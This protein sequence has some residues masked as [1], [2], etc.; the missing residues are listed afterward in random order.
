MA[1]TNYVATATPSAGGEQVT[2]FVV[3][4]GTD[5]YIVPQEGT[6]F[7]LD[8]G[9]LT[10][11]QANAVQVDPATV[12]LKSLNLETRVINDLTAT[13]GPITPGVGYD[14]IGSITIN[15]VRLETPEAFT[16]EQAASAG[17]STIQKQEADAWGLGI[18]TVNKVLV[19]EKTAV[20]SEAEAPVTP[21]SG[22]LLSKVT[23]PG[24]PVD[25]EFSKT[26]NPSTV[27]QKLTIT[28]GKYI[29]GTLTVNPVILQD[30]GVVNPTTTQQDARDVVPLTGGA[31]GY[32]NFKVGAVQ[33][34]TLTVKST[35]SQETKNPTSGKFFSQVTVQPISLQTKTVDNLSTQTGAI[36]ADAG[37]DGLG[38]VTV[39]SVLLDTPATFT[40]EELVEGAGGGETSA[41]VGQAVV[42]KARVGSE[43]SEDP[44]YS[45]IG[46]T[47]EGAW[48]VTEV[49]VNKIP[50]TDITVKS[51]AEDQ[52]VTDPS[53]RYI[54][55]V[56]VEKLNIQ[57]NKTVSAADNTPTPVTPDE[58]Y[59][60]LAKVT[61]SGIPIVSGNS[62][63]PSL[64]GDT[65]VAEN[66]YWKN[67][68]VAPVPLQDAGTIPPG[69]VPTPAPALTG[70]NI[71]YS[72]FTV[73]AIPLYTPNAVDPSTKLQTIGQ[74]GQYMKTV[75][76][77]AIQVEEKSETP[78]LEAK[79]VV[80]TPGKYLTKV[81]VEATPLADAVTFTPN[82]ETQTAQL[83]SNIGVKGVTVNPVPL[84]TDFNKTFEGSK[85]D[86]ERTVAEGKYINGT[87][88]ARG[89]T[90]VLRTGVE[91]DPLIT[92]QAFPVEEGFDGYGDFTV[93]EI[94]IYRPTDVIPS[95]KLQEIKEDGKY[96][97][98]VRV[99]PV[100]TEEL[101]VKSTIGGED[102]EA[103]ISEGKFV[104]KVTVQALKAQTK[105]V[106]A[107]DNVDTP[108]TPDA[109]YDALT[110]VNVKGIP[111]DT[112]NNIITPKMGES[113]TV[114]AEGYFKTATAT[115]YTVKLQSRRVDPS[116]AEET[117]QAEEGYDGLLEVV[118]SPI[119]TESKTV[120][121]S[122]EQ[123]IVKP[124]EEGKYLKLVTVNGYVPNVHPV[125]VDELKVGQKI[126]TERG[127]DGISEVTINGVK[128]QDMTVSGLKSEQEVVKTEPE[129]WGLGTVTV[130]GYAPVLQTKV[131]N[132]ENPLTTTTGAITAD[133]GYDGL[134]SVSVES[135]KLENATVNPTA[136]GTSVAKTDPAAWGL[137]TVTVNAPNLEEELLVT[138]TDAEQ[139][140]KP[141]T[142]LG[143]KSVKVKAVPLDTVNNHYTP[144]VDGETLFP[145][146]GKFFQ[147]FRVEA[148]PLQEAISVDPSKE[149]QTFNV[150]P[151]SLG[152]KGVVV[153]AVPKATNNT[154]TPT[155]EG[156]TIE[157]EDGFFYDFT[158]DPAPLEEVQTFTPNENVQTTT[159]T[160]GKIGV[161]GA[162][163]NPV[164]L[165]DTPDIEFTP[166]REGMSIDAGLDGKY[167]RSVTVDP[168]PSE[169]LR[170]V[171]SESEQIFPAEGENVFYSKVTVAADVD[172]DLQEKT[173]T[174]DRATQTITPDAG[175]GG[176]SRITVIAPID[177]GITVQ[178]GTATEEKK[179][180]GLGFKS[181]SVTGDAD[182]IAE[183]IKKDVDILGVVGTYDGPEEGGDT[184]PTGGDGEVEAGF[185]AGDT[186][187]LDLPT[188]ITRSE[189]FRAAPY[190]K[191]HY[192]GKTFDGGNY[193][194]ITVYSRYGKPV[195]TV[196]LNDI[197]GKLYI[198]K[199]DLT[200]PVVVSETLNLGEDIDSS[201]VDWSVITEIR[202]NGHVITV[203]APME[204]AA[205]KDFK[206]SSVVF[207]MRAV[208]ENPFI[209]TSSS[210]TLDDCVASGLTSQALKSHTVRLTDCVIQGSGAEDKYLIDAQNSDLYIEGTTFQ[211]VNGV[212]VTGGVTTMRANVFM[213]TGNSICMA[214]NVS[215]MTLEGNIF[216]N[217]SGSELKIDSAVTNTE[218]VKV[219]GAIEIEGGYHLEGN[220]PVKDEDAP[221]PPAEKTPVE[222]VKGFFDELS[223]D[224]VSDYLVE[225]KD[226]IMTAFGVEEGGSASS[227]G[228][229]LYNKL[230]GGDTIS[231]TLN[232]GG[233]LNINGHFDEGGEDLWTM[234]IE[235]IVPEGG[236]NKCFP[237][238]SGYLVKSGTVVLRTTE[239]EITDT[240][241]YDIALCLYS[242][243]FDI[244][245]AVIS[246]GETER[247]LTVS[248]LT[249]PTDLDNPCIIDP[250]GATYEITVHDF[251]LPP[252]DAEGTVA[253]DGEPVEWSEIV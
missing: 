44:G 244:S 183:N 137:N 81:T 194:A 80:P 64:E 27:S 154:Y 239:G 166:D 193:M 223:Q 43:G 192:L 188:S 66:G 14:G 70:G 77:N 99:Q 180:T 93:K 28:T 147:A 155:L 233:K 83:G 200:P 157:A 177:E 125:V 22:Y 238:G 100:P 249:K 221:E 3:Y 16:P 215:E 148:A 245:S 246:D 150:T 45:V 13:N 190:Y 139:T 52:E 51:T 167:F 230:Q 47:T 59:D 234:N 26:I 158:V 216:N 151:P 58:G 204:P 87:I 211:S 30:A 29:T 179:P 96:M 126:Y 205:G 72:T 146:E 9:V 123:V 214:G 206:A 218:N 237:A 240:L 143:Y 42:G 107:K 224:A 50:V 222:F 98:S 94:P 161:K 25:T 219:I 133:E 186:V 231:I 253:L 92:S 53:S 84:D 164:P 196:L 109:G 128:L 79:D 242:Y 54:K 201:E 85:T 207:D 129:A 7:N 11:T 159:L 169:E 10:V 55:T 132:T 36:T 63:T 178:S 243:S 120:E 220:T 118:V 197:L 62:Y 33:T 110:Q 247:T 23:V 69:E 121:A 4:N 176:I 119:Q 68:T 15:S 212:R 24:I 156:D 252:A 37:Y 175:Y 122:K 189:S 202:G 19:Q 168:V 41:I 251:V 111:I 60:Y 32:S 75:T 187:A 217:L 114:T 241:E 127:Y 104:S 198:E 136:E 227:I 86:Q 149:E 191:G 209:G 248:G 106:S 90:P 226:V 8:A 213:T 173:V 138:P 160:G 78:G 152:Y 112:T 82:G 199:V 141:E 73:G 174:L 103:T 236:T 165:M 49:K 21:D 115:G 89:Y 184:P 105:E 145:E 67:F 140:K 170:V 225:N 101:T 124:S 65:L 56:N 1:I 6:T 18:V 163:V 57:D 108:V 172:V 131:F 48:G 228:E 91:I 38:S 142:A 61:V 102:T 76:V 135:V 31:M 210:I 71:G 88:L 203:S 74:S 17:T 171:A 185:V 39:S 134:L 113:V 20:L 232:D 117:I 95:G 208:P 250:N 162:R 5:A 97:T 235:Y 46:A 40:P 116:E 12:R 195:A 130:N 229:A 181:V 153:H 35:T 34:E 182:L 144:T 2:G